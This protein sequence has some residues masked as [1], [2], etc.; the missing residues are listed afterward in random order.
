MRTPMIAGNWKM[1]GTVG[2]AEILVK[3]MLPALDRI[4]GV[5]KVVCPPFVALER[6]SS[7]LRGSTISVGAQNMHHHDRGAFTGEI[8]PLMLADLCQYV[9][10][11]H[12][13]RRQFF[14]DTDE[15]VNLKVTA[16]LN[17]GLWT[18]VCIGENLEQRD[19]GETARVVIGQI[20]GALD[21]VPWSEAITIAYE[22]I[23]AIGTGRAATAE[24]AE[25]TI[26]LIRDELASLYSPQE[27]DQVRILYG[28]SVTPDNI[29]ELISQKEID[30]ALVGGA[31]LRAES[32]VAIVEKT[33]EVQGV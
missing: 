15:I 17:H 24:Q 33:S 28:G 13:E 20:R 4:T 10:L 31:S 8:S 18:I 25:E 23:W 19:A 11:G 29:L 26:A 9:I 6:V 7:L 2:E 22:P 27:A 1:N 14:G 30:G 12:S 3:A 32:F 5:E 21:G 16:A